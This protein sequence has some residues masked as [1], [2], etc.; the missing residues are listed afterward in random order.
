LKNLIERFVV[1]SS[2]PVITNDDLP[3]VMKACLRQKGSAG[4]AA[5]DSGFGFEDRLA[6]FERDMINETLAK[7]GGNKTEAAALLGISRYSLL[8][9]IKRL[10]NAGF[11]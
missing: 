2:D 9:K 6:T 8:R 3:T 7:C 4:T 1:L 10:S 5:R 11:S